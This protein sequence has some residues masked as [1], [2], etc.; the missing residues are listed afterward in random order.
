GGCRRKGRSRPGCD[1]YYARNPPS[2]RRGT[3]SGAD[4]D[5][6]RGIAG[7][8]RPARDWAA[9]YERARPRGGR[10]GDRGAIAPVPAGPGLSFDPGPLRRTRTPTPTE[11]C[12]TVYDRWK[13]GRQQAR[14]VSSASGSGV[15]AGPG[16]A[17][18][19]RATTPVNYP[20]Q[21]AAFV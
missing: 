11:R 15:C 8:G 9:Y 13:A 4:R 1:A 3:R 6:G 18:D 14:P 5:T 16:A 21:P 7:R 2:G 19:G 12:Q 20:E 10:R 17:L